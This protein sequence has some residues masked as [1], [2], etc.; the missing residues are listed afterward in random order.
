MTTNEN[1][2]PG[3]LPG[4]GVE[5]NCASHFSPASA[6]PS[7]GP[8]PTLDVPPIIDW[9]APGAHALLSGLASARLSGK[10]L[11]RRRP[12]LLLRLSAAEGRNLIIKPTLV[13]SPTGWRLLDRLPMELVS[14][15]P[16]GIGATLPPDDQPIINRW[17]KDRARTMGELAILRATL[18]GFATDPAGAVRLGLL[19]C[20]VC[21]RKL[22]DPASIAR[23]IGPECWA[24]FEAV[25]QAVQARLMEKRRHG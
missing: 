13:S 18:Q 12:S 9:I 25:I 5:S 15:R 1:A 21:Q 6:Y 7:I 8:A 17:W 20:A 22:T 23:G 14:E 4:N 19:H 11:S 10:E 2:A 3:W 16:G 24:P